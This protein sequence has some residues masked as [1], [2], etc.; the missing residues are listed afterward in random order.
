MGHQKI[1]K[2]QKEKDDQKINS[3][4]FGAKMPNGR[5]KQPTDKFIICVEWAERIINLKRIS[6]KELESAVSTLQFGVMGI[7][8]GNIYLRRS[9][10]ALHVKKLW[11]GKLFQEEFVL[12]KCGWKGRYSRS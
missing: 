11:K 3:R 7:D 4:Y 5:S 6:H 2:E 1:R 10:R 12:L 9:F 8:N